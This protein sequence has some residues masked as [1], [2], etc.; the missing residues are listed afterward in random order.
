MAAKLNLHGQ[1][2]S[3]L[4]VVSEAA[5]A[6][7]PKAATRWLCR[8]DCGTEIVTETGALRSGHTKSCGCMHRDIVALN[9]VKHGLYGSPEYRAWRAMVARCTVETNGS[10][11]NYGGRGI[12]VCDQW[13][14]FEN[15]FADMGKRP[16]GSS[17]DRIDNN[18]NYEPSNCRWA[19]RE[20]QDNNKRTNVMVTFEGRTMTYSQWGKELRTAPSILRRRWL[21][22]GTLHPIQRSKESYC[23]KANR[24]HTGI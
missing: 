8:C 14:L 11:P 15:F 19:N 21:K 16:T 23:A 9:S 17:I 10:F 7:R 1:K 3:R 12:K 5:K 20:Q 6:D 22:F 13:M 18:G 24:A 2:F 4:T